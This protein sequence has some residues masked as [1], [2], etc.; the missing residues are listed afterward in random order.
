ML[1]ENEI[2]TIFNANNI[3]AYETKTALDEDVDIVL[4]T[5]NVDDFIDFLQKNDVNTVFFNYVYE[6]KECYYIE[7]EDMDTE[8]PYID[9]PI[10]DDYK[11]TFS[12]EKSKFNKRI[13]HCDFSKPTYLS[14][15]CIFNGLQV[16]MIQ[17]DLW[18]NKVPDK[19]DFLINLSLEFDKKYQVWKEKL[20]EDNN[21]K[22]EEAFNKLKK[23]ID[24]SED[25]YICTN[26]Q[27]RRSYCYELIEQY[28]K[29]YGVRLFDFEV[30]DYLEKKWNERKL[31]IARAKKEK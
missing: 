2:Y 16:G 24:F 7:D 29:E 31:S 5:D 27:L 25:W 15:Y 19:F 17:Q 30:R 6:D 3:N 10:Y 21:I 4:K 18:I 1:K 9:T 22:Y 11:K 13:S 14:I 20:E 23:H 28:E 8:V 26:Q 12:E